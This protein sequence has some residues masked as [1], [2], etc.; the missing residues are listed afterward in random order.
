MT[1]ILRVEHRRHD[2][3]GVIV[4]RRAPVRPRILAIV[5][6]G[7]ERDL[8]GRSISTEPE[9]IRVRKGEERILAPAVRPGDKSAHQE[10][11]EE[12]EEEE[13]DGRVS[14]PHPVSPPAAKSH[15]PRRLH[16]LRQQLNQVG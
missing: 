9:R 16:R 5:E 12:E 6:I 13:G 14:S 8:E 10:V 15:T 2:S 7:E 3:I 11:A 1:W 4:L